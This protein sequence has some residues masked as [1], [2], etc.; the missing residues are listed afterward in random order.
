MP[1]AICSKEQVPGVG[2]GGRSENVVDVHFS[3]HR[4]EERKHSIGSDHVE[5][6]SAGSDLDFL[7]VEIAGAP[8]IGKDFRPGIFAEFDELRA[9][10]IVGID[11]GS[12]RRLGPAAFEKNALGVEIL[13]HGAVVVE[14]I[15]GEI[16]EDRDVEWDGKHALLRERVRRD[17]HHGF[18]RTLADALC[19]HL[20]EFERFG[21]GVRCGQDLSGHVIFDRAD[22]QALATGRAQN[23]FEQKCAGALPVGAGDAGD[24]ETLGG[25]LVEIR[26]QTGQRAATVRNLRPGDSRARLAPLQNR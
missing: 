22:Q 14:V 1:A 7:G 9:V 15:A 16:G 8:T 18:G 5:A 3:E 19:Q 6:R 2:R 26:A 4:R 24:R 20:V 11:H 17:F 12:A 13:F 25:L 21:R 23:R 10:F